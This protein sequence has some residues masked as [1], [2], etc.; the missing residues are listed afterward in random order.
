MQVFAKL[1]EGGETKWY[2]YVRKLQWI[3]NITIT[4]STKHSLFQLMIDVKMKDEDKQNNRE[5]VEE[6]YKK[7]VIE[8]RVNLR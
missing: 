1:S 7:H 2:K 6:E 4:R 5:V 3:I 8:V